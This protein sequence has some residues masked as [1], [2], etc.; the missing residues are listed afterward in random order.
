MNG[1]VHWQIGCLVGW[2][3]PDSVDFLDNLIG[4]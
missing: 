4:I 1:G 3:L 2:T